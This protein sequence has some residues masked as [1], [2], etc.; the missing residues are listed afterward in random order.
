MSELQTFLV[1]QFHR[2][3]NER[4][5][6]SERLRNQN[7]Y[8]DSWNQSRNSFKIIAGISIS[9]ENLEIHRI[10]RSN[11]SKDHPRFNEEIKTFLELRKT[12]YDH[13]NDSV[14]IRWFTLDDLLEHFIKGT[15]SFVRDPKKCQLRNYFSDVA[16]AI[17]IR[18]R[19]NLENVLFHLLSSARE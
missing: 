19:I 16:N 17:F 15:L 14:K 10:C 9:S 18:S 2:E 12:L 3:Q 1:M 8:Q 6:N 11:S 7:C 13:K 4:H 5:W